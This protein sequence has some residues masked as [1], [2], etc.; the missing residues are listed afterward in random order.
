MKYKIYL[1]NWTATVPI[2]LFQ[3]KAKTSGAPNTHT[4][5]THAISATDSM[6]LIQKVKH[7]TGSPNWNV[8]VLD[9]HLQKCL[10]M[11][12]SGYTRVKWN[13]RADRLAGKATIISGSHL[14]RYKVLR[15]FRH[16]LWAQSHRHHTTDRLED[17]GVENG[18][19]RWCSLKNK[20][21][22]SSI[23]WTL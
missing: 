9:L 13:H 16:C 5:Y 22:S 18:S 15:N 3:P 21:V 20:R 12:C 4:S 6:K 19:A 23:R 11:Y 17:W 10:W 1:R 7:A 14:G 2:R 8:S